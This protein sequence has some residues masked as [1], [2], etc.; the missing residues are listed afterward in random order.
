[1]NDKLIEKLAS[2]V[3]QMWLEWMLYMFDRS[4][5]CADGAT[6]IP[7]KL[8]EQWILKVETNYEDLSENEKES[9]QKEAR[10]I[11]EI[12]DRIKK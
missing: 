8:T 11:I 1:M 12:I 7:A 4:I 2:Y 10:K 9:Y 6:L 3:Y 5:S